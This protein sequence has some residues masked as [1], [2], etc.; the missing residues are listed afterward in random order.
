MK[1]TARETT[2]HLS[3]LF[4]LHNDL[5]TLTAH[6]YPEHSNHSRYRLERCDPCI[7]ASYSSSP[8]S[9]ETAE[10]H[11][12]S[13]ILQVNQWKHSWTS[14]HT[15]DWNHCFPVLAKSMAQRSNFLC[16][17][18]LQLIRQSRRKPDERN[19]A[20]RNTTTS[21]LPISVRFFRPVY[22]P[23]FGPLCF[24]N[25]FSIYWTQILEMIWL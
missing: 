3:P 9:V 19:W 10:H 23:Q 13:L 1:K 14:E 15:P 21:Q 25:R 12:S 24:E 11:V 8:S 7:S 4:S 17:I 18:Q 2:L 20:L 5:H 16:S 6:R 22:E